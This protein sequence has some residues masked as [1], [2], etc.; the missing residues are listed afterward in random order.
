M[1]YFTRVLLF[2]VAMSATPAFAQM[3]CGNH[4]DIT[5][6][7][8]AGYQEALSGIGV[9]S[10]GGVIE[11][12]TSK[13]GT[14][15]ILLTRPNGMSCLMAVGQNWESVEKDPTPGAST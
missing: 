6:Q 9:A 10:N 1:T 4:S 8:Q 7:L 5:R 13:K 3:V 12:Y 11:L 15:T 2:V 14:F